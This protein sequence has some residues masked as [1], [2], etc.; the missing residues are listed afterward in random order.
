MVAAFHPRGSKAVFDCRDRGQGIAAM[1]EAFTL[2]L[3]EAH[4]R[5]E[6]GGV[7]GLGGSGGTALITAAMRALPIGLP[8][9]MVSTVAS[10]NVAPYIDCTDITMM[11]SVVDI[12]GLNFVSRMVLRNAAHALAGMMGGR[13]DVSTDRP[14]LGMTMFGVTTPCVDAVRTSLETDG[15]QC[16]VFHATGSGGRA[17]ENL[18]DSGM[19]RGVLD[20]TTTEVA[21]EVVGGVFPAGPKRIDAILNQAIPYVMSL[22]AL[23]MVNFGAPETVPVQFRDRRFHVH[24]PQVTLMR[25]TPDENRQF[26][27]WI[28]AK[29]NRSVSPVTLVIP[30]EGL[31]ALDREGQPFHDP[32]ADAA[33]FEELES[34]VHPTANVRI[35]RLP[36]HINDPAFSLALIDEFRQLWARQSQPGAC[37]C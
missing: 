17:M 36:L 10:G 7:L 21:D 14:A 31:S 30:E 24:N 32:K 25:T 37:A 26:A 20:I 19:I 16:L 8:K 15:Y 35:R 23:D 5:G 22:G 28:A 13:F 4:R 12:A 34:A 9:V 2:F 33:L 1:G 6:V 11:H 27:R 18:V 3:K 29:L